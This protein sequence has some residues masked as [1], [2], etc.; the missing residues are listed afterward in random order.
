M[1]QEMKGQSKLPPYLA[2]PRFLM[3]SDL[4]DSTKLVYV[5]LLD[6]ARLSKKNM[7]W[8]NGD[9]YVYVHYTIKSMSEAIGK[10]EMTVKKAYKSLEEAGLIR[11]ERQ[12]KNHPNRIY[13]RLPGQ[14][15]NCPQEG[16]NA[17]PQGGKKLSGNKNGNSKPNP[18]RNYELGDFL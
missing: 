13:V 10:C 2:Y 18:V 1:L 8:T 4:P 14:T 11:R 9:G 5:L 16:Q 15:E 12:G 17:V 3:K 6:R 7:V